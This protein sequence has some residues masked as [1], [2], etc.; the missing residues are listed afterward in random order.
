[1]GALTATL[2]AMFERTG[3]KVVRHATK[4]VP[5]SVGARSA[6]VGQCDLTQL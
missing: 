2:L 6:S 5:L 1:M 4:R 3:W